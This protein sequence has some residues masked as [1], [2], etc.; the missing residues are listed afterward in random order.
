MSAQSVMRVLAWLMPTFERSDIVDS[1]IDPINGRGWRIAEIDAHGT[2]TDYTYDAKGRLVRTEHPDGSAT[3]TTYNGID[4][5]ERECDALDRCTEHAYDARGN[6]TRTTYPDATWE[7][8]G[9]DANGNVTSQRDRG[10]R[11]TRMVYDRANRLV[12]TIHPDASPASGDDGNPANN[13]RT[14]NE[15]DDAGRLVATID[16][17]GQRTT[18]A[19]DDAGRRTS[20]TAPPVD[21]PTGPQAATT[22]TTYDAAG[23]RIAE[24]DALGRT[25]RH[26][27]DAA[28]RVITVIHPDVDADDGNDA[29]N[30][31]T[32][33][34]YDATGR[35]IAET[36]EAGR[37]TRYAYDRLGRLIAVALPNPD[38][39]ANPPLAVTPASTGGGVAG[40]AP[41]YT[42]TSP[43]PGVLITTY[44]YDERGNRIAQTD[45]AGRT[46][47]WTHD[48]MGRETSR[49]LPMGQV[50]T[51][52][53]DAVGRRL[54]HT[55]FAGQITRHA[56]DAADRIVRTDYADGRV[57]THV[58][59]AVG[60]RTETITPEGAYTWL[61]DARGRLLRTT[62]PGDLAI[63]YAWDEAGNRIAMWDI[64]G[65]APVQTST[66][67]RYGLDSRGRLLSLRSGTDPAVTHAYDAVGNVVREVQGALVTT[68]D[69][70]RRNRLRS[71]ETRR[72]DAL[73]HRVSYV[74]DAVGRRTAMTTTDDTGIVR[75][76]TYRY[77]AVG[78]LVEE[79]ER[80]AGTITEQSR[81]AYDRVGNRTTVEEG[82]VVSTASFDANDR[83]LASGDIAFAYDANG[84]LT[85][86]SGPA[87]T[88]TYGYDARQRLVEVTAATG[89]QFR[90][91]YDAD[92][93]RV[94]RSVRATPGA[95]PID[96][97]FLVDRAMALPEVVAEVD[98]SHAIAARYLH[99]HELVQQVTRQGGEQRLRYPLR[100][101]LGSSLA[102]A[103]G[104][105]TVT[106]RYR[107]TPWGTDR[108]SSGDTATAHRYAGEMWEREIGLSYNRARWY[109]PSQGRLTQMDV[110]AGFATD[111]RSLHKYGYA[112]GDPVNG[113]D[114]SGLLLMGDLVAAKQIVALL[115]VGAL[116]GVESS[117]EFMIQLEAEAIPAAIHAARTNARRGTPGIP[118]IFYGTDVFQ[119]ADHIDYAQSEKAI[120]PILTKRHQRHS[121]SWVRDTDECR[122]RTQLGSGKEC[123]EYPF[124]ITDEGGRGR[125]PSAVSLRPL[126]QV[127]N[128]RAGNRLGR[129][130]D[131]CGVDAAAP[132][133][134]LFAVVAVAD[135]GPSGYACRDGT[136][137]LF[138]P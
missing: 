120:S 69:Y 73:V 90:F 57:E 22:T 74:H 79:I 58:Y 46:T 116:I 42:T 123:D 33:T 70:D 51:T 105:G 65:L 2:R 138:G 137:R 86:Q 96:T 39:G 63:E 36:D 26:V 1:E 88:Q 56:H 131:Y 107:Y 71:I 25:T 136:P 102:L 83:L 30:P 134:K 129:F 48:R 9:Y 4:K 97:R 24:T 76:T 13:P 41:V 47:R 117:S 15:Y 6:R 37:S 93:N 11:T 128:S 133:R 127:M 112:H 17:R 43:D 66:E 62:Q 92:G 60:E 28:G 16:E 84:N 64:V 35:K 49:T 12:E 53:Y 135:G 124:A 100:D 54:T 5:P 109:A 27:H 67:T 98:A 81:Y 19:Y 59:N 126:S 78:R 94:G 101:G 111:P 34:T 8:T 20:V 91:T 95:P 75:E 132:T 52:T 125:Y 3:T 40:P 110:F 21:T 118:T 99:G 68:R 55:S 85:S 89:Q 122:G 106:D 23:Q 114:P 31:R 32:H 29:N 87:G 113:A 38:T 115:V 121:S 7:E 130:F 61:H 77:D 44:A 103:D 108:I 72:A 45:A 50:E 14:R 18:Y 104:A 80:V 82:G 10:G 119:V